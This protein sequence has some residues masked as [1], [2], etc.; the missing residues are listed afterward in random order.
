MTNHARRLVQLAS[1][2]VLTT[3][4]CLVTNAAGPRFFDDDPIQQQPIT[5]DVTKAVRYEPDLTFQTLEALFTSPGG[6]VTDVRAQNVNTVDEVPDGPFYA[7]RAGKM[8]L[9]PETVARAANTS[10]G[11][12]PGPWTIVSAKSDGITP[13]FTIRDSAKTLWFIKFDPPGWKGMATGTEVVAAKLFWS[14]GYHTVEYHIGHLQRS[15]LVVDPEARITPVGEVERAMANRDIDRLLS[16]ADRDSDG[17]YRVILSKAAPGRPV[18]R[19]RFHGTRADDPNDIVPHQHHRELR[20]YKVFSA[21]LNHVDAKGINSIATL[22]T[23][24]GRTFIRQY[25]LDFG[26]A[27]GSAA[28]GPREGWEG[29]EELLEKPGD[30]GKGVLSF[31]FR[32]PEWRKVPW[33]E[34]PAVGRLPKTQDQWDPRKWMPRI[35]NGAFNHMRAD[36]AFWAAEKLT[37]ITD[38]MIDAAVSEGQFGN[39]EASRE[40]ARFIRERRDRILQTY[41]PAVNPVT[42]PSIENDQLHFRNAAVEAGVAKPPSGYRVAFFSFDNNTDTAKPLTEAG[43]TGGVAG[44]GKAEASGTISVPLPPKVDSAF[45]KAEISATGGPAEWAKPITVYF[46]RA[47][48]VWRLVGLE[49]LP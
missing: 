15:N 41:L 19:I 17:T 44:G 25:M 46:R 45:I 47:G 31:G 9:T 38:P 42:R 18:G 16:S 14:V 32:V 11:P 8:D 10:G 6:P 2:F 27:L 36:D 35:S 22:V 39:E 13:G 21:W 29:Y 4:L 24:N 28:I 26:S 37:Y 40:L 43:V 33:Y 20:G 1:G 3:A 5:Q 12:A 30:I 48:Q 34:S 23:E 49:R 7:N